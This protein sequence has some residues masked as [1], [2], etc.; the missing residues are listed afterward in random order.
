MDTETI[1][2]LVE[3]LAGDIDALEEALAPLISEALAASTSKLPL[4]DKAKLYVLATY[5]IESILFSY[6]RLN[7][8][9]AKEHPI[10]RELTRVKEYFGKIKAAEGISVDGNASGARLDKT[11]ADRVIKAGLSG[12]ARHD[13]ARLA[14]E[15]A[16]AKRR[17]E[18]MGAG[19][20]MR[21]D[22]APK[23]AKAAAPQQQVRVVKFDDIDDS[24]SSSSD[25]EA[26][27]GSNESS[28]VNAAK[29]DDSKPN[30]KSSKKPKKKARQE[31]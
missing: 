14:R 10:F 30:A 31:G 11:A 23:K 3:D 21:F 4:L 15:T 29:D 19:K 8:V 25:D 18:D 2:D 20:H 26:A 5:A 17:L 16:G 7:G 24:S 22:D 12:N 9:Q 6:L 1:T 28:Q 27:N 13:Q